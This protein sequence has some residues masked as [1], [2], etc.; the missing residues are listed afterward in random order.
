MYAIF[1]VLFVGALSVVS[2]QGQIM[3]GQYSVNTNSAGYTLDKGSGDRTYTVEVSYP[4]GFEKKPTVVAMVTTV[5]AEKSTNVRYSIAV[6]AVSRDGFIIKVTT[7]GDTKLYGLGG[8]W[9]AYSE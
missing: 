1:I 7:W 5:D 3:S 4:T 6:T 2:A 8:S 9:I